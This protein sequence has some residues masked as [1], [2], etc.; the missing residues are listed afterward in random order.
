MGDLLKDNYNVDYIT[1]LAKDFYKYEKSFNRSKF[2]KQ[3]F[4]SE[5]NDLELKG[6]M[7]HIVSVINIMIGELTFSKQVELLLKVAPE[8]RGFEGMFF[9]EYISTFCDMN[10]KQQ[11]RKSIRALEVLTQYSSSEFAIRKF[12]KKD[13][14]TTLAILLRWADHENFHVRR[15]A[16]EGCRP[17]LPWSFQLTHFV[18]NPRP[19]LPILE[20]LIDD[21]SEY[22]RRSVSNNVNDIS[23]DHPQLVITKARKWLKKPSRFKLVKHGLRTLLKNGNVEALEL[24][25]YGKVNDVSG[26]KLSV[27]KKVH[28]PGE[29]EISG[30]FALKKS[31]KVRLEFA[32]YFLKKNGSYTK[33]V[34]KISEREFLKGPHVISKKY[35]FK[36]ISTR[37][38][39]DGVHMVSLII[40]G[41]E[42]KKEKFTLVMR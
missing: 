8:Y 7:A 42:S 5:W 37:K 28:F 22:V 13:T 26:L 21:P 32:L 33:K 31:A 35:H 15:L 23:K 2:L 25:G 30:G 18:D 14:E 11:W 34:F 4:N 10:N 16:S 17:R 3:I 29:L 12:I 41:K 19:L 20:K 24:M 36:N 6:R 39:H 38:Y 27:N 9:P 40:N 1:R